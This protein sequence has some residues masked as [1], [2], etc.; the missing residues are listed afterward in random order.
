MTWLIGDWSPIHSVERALEERWRQHCKGPGVYRLIGLRGALTPACI[1]R[2]CGTDRT[3][4]LYIGHSINLYTRVGNLVRAHRSNDGISH[5]AAF[6][7]KLKG[8]FPIRRLGVSW[9][10]VDSKWIR[11]RETELIDDYIAEFGD[12]PP[13]N[14]NA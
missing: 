13:L 10:G 6:P 14:A 3:G 4:T 1:S 12:R 7:D 11:N 5:H 2:A 8:R 9:Q